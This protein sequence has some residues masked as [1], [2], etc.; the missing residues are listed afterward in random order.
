MTKTKALILVAA[1]AQRMGTVRQDS[2]LVAVQQNN[3]S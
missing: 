2:L 3:R 1:A